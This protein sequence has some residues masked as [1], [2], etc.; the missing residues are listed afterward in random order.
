MAMTLLTL[1][2][3]M[4]MLPGVAYAMATTILQILPKPN[5][6][7]QSEICLNLTSRVRFPANLNHRPQKKAEWF[8]NVRTRTRSNF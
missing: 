7:R 3:L 4:I 2:G 5:A 8:E 6:S 1:K